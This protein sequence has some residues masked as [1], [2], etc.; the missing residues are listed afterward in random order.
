MPLSHSST[1]RGP[2]CVAAAFTR[3]RRDHR[4]TF[5]RTSAGALALVIAV[6]AIA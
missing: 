6:L 4:A 2:W 5:C 3:R 1:V